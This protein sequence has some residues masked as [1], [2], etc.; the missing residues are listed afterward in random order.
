ME[1]ADNVYNTELKEID[2]FVDQQ[3]PHHASI[4]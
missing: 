2:G 4:R 3:V 1:E